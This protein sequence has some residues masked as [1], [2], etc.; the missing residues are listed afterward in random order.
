M[1]VSIVAWDLFFYYFYNYL[2]PL[3]VT[4]VHSKI[5]ARIHPLIQNNLSQL[6]KLALDAR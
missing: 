2:Y 6:L 3:M 1:I 5:N 4:H